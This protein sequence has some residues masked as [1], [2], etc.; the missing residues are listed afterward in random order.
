MVYYRGVPIERLVL[1]AIGVF[2]EEPGVGPISPSQVPQA[3]EDRPYL[4]IHRAMARMLHA[5]KR[6]ESRT[7]MP[8]GQFVADEPGEGHG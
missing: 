7:F 4:P 8:G 5:D 6:Y 1:D 2:I 3:A